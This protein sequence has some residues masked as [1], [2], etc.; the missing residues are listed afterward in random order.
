VLAVATKFHPS[1]VTVMVPFYA[2][3]G[4][5]FTTLAASEIRMEKYGV[6]GRG[7]ADSN[8]GRNV[9]AGSIVTFVKTKAIPNITE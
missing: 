4:V 7:P 1:K 3:S 9:P 2:M 6:L 5:S 8:A